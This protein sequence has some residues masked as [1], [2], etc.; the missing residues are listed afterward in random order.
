MMLDER[1]DTEL[2]RLLEQGEADAR[3]AVIM[4][5]SG[6]VRGIASRY[7]SRGFTF[8]DICQVGYL[9]LIQAVDRFDP[10]GASHCRPMPTA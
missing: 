3:D 4:R 7:S 8:E 10:A 6:L 2:L 5:Y 9:G 1:S